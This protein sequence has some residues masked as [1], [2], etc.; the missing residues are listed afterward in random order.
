[1]RVHDGYCSTRHI[2]GVVGPEMAKSGRAEEFDIQPRTTLN[3]FSS[4]FSECGRKANE[5][6]RMGRKGGQAL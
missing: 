6:S 5:E 2:F 4:V 1:M 3:E